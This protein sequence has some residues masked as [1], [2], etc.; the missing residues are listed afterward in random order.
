[1]RGTAAATV[2]AVSAV[3]RAAASGCPSRT[4]SQH[5]FAT[6]TPTYDTDREETGASGATAVRPQRVRQQGPTRSMGDR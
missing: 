5:C 2:P 6:D 1:M 4:T 3:P